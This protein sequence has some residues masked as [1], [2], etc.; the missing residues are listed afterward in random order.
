MLPIQV[1]D[2]RVRFEGVPRHWFAGHAA[3]THL[4]NALN[5]LF[6]AGER[7]F[8]RSVRYYAD[9]F[10]DP[11]IQEQMRQFFGQEGSHA[12]EHQ[13]FFEVLEA[14]GFEVERFLGAYERFSLGIEKLM[15]PALRLA[16]T[17]AAEHFTASLADNAL[18]SSVF[19]E[20]HPAMRE[21]LLW[22]A[23]EEIEHKAVAYDVLQAV[24]SSRA[25][26][27]AGLA[28]ATTLL[29]T[30]WMIAFVMFAKQDGMT[31]REAFASLRDADVEGRHEAPQTVM[32]RALKEY[33]APDFHPWNH[34]NSDLASRFLK[35]MPSAA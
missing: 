6:P 7:F 35:S 11:A 25:L 30:W 8:I 20:I 4:S 15:P 21:L 10:D 12:R 22:H 33:L 16:T 32:R 3:A 34:D 19:E 2:V 24:N 29:V 5:M 17:A 28:T 9:R 26:R 13:R 27:A 18:R 31:V 23:A 14:Q 1:R